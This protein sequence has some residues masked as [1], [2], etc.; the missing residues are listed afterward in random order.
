MNALLQCDSF[1]WTQSS[2]WPQT[3]KLSG[4]IRRLTAQHTVTKI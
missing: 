4:K 3:M 1:N 2:Q